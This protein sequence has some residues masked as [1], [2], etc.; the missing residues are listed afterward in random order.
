MIKSLIK[1]KNE[2]PKLVLAIAIPTFPIWFVLYF[3]VFFVIIIFVIIYDI[4]VNIFNLPSKRLF[5]NIMIDKNFK[6]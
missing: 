2:H 4:I 3:I 6:K 1:F 5:P